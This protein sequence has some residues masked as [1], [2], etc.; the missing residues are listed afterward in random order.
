MG[1]FVESAF[2]TGLY[3]DTY[4]QMFFKLG[5]VLYMTKLQVKVPVLISLTSSQGHRVMGQLKLEQLF[6]CKKA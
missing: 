1:E 6:C 5:M 3:S 4:E 2:N